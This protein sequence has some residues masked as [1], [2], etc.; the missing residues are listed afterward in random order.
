ML[1]Q[2]RVYILKFQVLESQLWIAVWPFR[3]SNLGHLLRSVK[4]E[5]FSIKDSR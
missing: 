3:V 4:V 2:N 5:A 1:K